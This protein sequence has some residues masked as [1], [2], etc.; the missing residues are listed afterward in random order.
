VISPLFRVPNESALAEKP[1]R[2]MLAVNAA[3]LI[4]VFFYKIS[5]E[6]YVSYIHLLVDYHFGFTKRALIG[7]QACPSPGQVA[8]IASLENAWALQIFDRLIRT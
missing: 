6:P 2:L 4:G 8:S 3:V 1:L 5:R 7:A